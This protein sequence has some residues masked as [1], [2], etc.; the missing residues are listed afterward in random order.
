V[1]TGQT[2]SVSVQQ[3]I[4]LGMFSIITYAVEMLLEYGV[5]H[6]VATIVTQIVQGAAL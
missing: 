4:Q 3:I 1:L 2:S 5:I 6:M